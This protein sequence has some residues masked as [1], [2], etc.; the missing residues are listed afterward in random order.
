MAQETKGAGN[1]DPEEAKS[2]VEA[3]EGL[4]FEVENLA[5]FSVSGSGITFLYDAGF[6][7]VIRA[8]APRGEYFFSY[9]ALKPYIKRDGLLGQFVN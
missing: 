6:P 4:R 8:F 1:M 9:A 7:H 2:I 3:F 5:E